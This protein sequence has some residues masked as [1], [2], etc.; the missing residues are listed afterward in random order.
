VRGYLLDT[1]IWLWLQSDPGRLSN[2]LVDALAD[3]QNQILLSAASSWE[4]S[5][6]YALG[7]LPLPEPPHRY[8]PDRMRRSG[9]TGLPVEHSHALAVAELPMIHSDPFDRLLI[10]QARSL[11]LTLV[12]ADRR[13]AE[14][15]DVD[16][17]LV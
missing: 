13:M 15:D 12:T 1:H 4:I 16:L 5:I 6:K 17:Q 2:E 11:S 10:V 9:T 8:V 3:E 14:Y 7:K